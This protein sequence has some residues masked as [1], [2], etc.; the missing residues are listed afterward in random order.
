MS[1]A[2][3]FLAGGTRHRGWWGVALRHKL[4]M[5][6]TTCCGIYATKRDCSAK[7]RKNKPIYGYGII[8]ATRA[9]ARMHAHYYRTIGYQ[10]IA[11]DK[12]SYLRY[13]HETC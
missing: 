6:S 2:V 3:N 8:L 10:T 4:S 5:V 13:W 12:R 7:R 9:R 11:K 1:S